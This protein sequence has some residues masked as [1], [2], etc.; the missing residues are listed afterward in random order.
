MF[1]SIDELRLLADG[2][3]AL[4]FAGLVIT[5]LYFAVRVRRTL[6]QVRTAKAD[7]LTDVEQRF[8]SLFSQSPDAVFAY[9]RDGYY[10]A[11]NPAA[12]AIVGF[13]DLDLGV[14]SYRDVAGGGAMHDADFAVFDT[15]FQ[16]ALEGESQTFEVRFTKKDGQRRN[17]ECVFLPILVNDEVVGV[18]SIVKDVTERNIAEEN[19]RILQKSLE[20]SDNAV[21]VVD[22]RDH[23]LPVVFANPAFTVMTGYRMDEVLGQP[24]KRLNG[25]D[26]DPQEIARISETVR[27]GRASSV[28]VK[29]YRRD[30]SPFWNQISLA[31]VKDEYG[32][33]THFTAIM[34]DIS[35]KKAQEKRLAYQATHDALTGLGNR[36][37][38]ED[39]LRHDFQLA[40]RRRNL[41]AVLFIDLDEFKPINDT[42]GHKVGDA[43]L[44]SIARRLQSLVRPAD[45]LARFGGDEFV[46]LLP[47]LNLLTQA[48]EVASRIL[49]SLAQPHQ[50]NGHELYISASIGISVIDDDLEYPEKLLQR[51]DMAMYKA[52][53]RGRDTYEIYS[54]DLDENL[55]RRVTLRNDLQEAISNDQLFLYYQP[56]VDGNGE[57]CGLEALVRWNHPDKGFISPED[58]IPLAEETGQIVQLGNWVTTRACHDARILLE[59]G[60]LR[61]R[62]AVNLS[63]MQFHRPG[64]LATLRSIL[65]QTGLAAE[66]LELELTEGILMKDACGAIATLKEMT[67]MGIATAID[68]FGTGFSS[69][70]YLKD[71]PVD[72]IK[73]DRS[74]VENVVTSPKDAAVCKGVIALAREMGLKVV[75][76]GVETREQ[77][78]YLRNNG[79]EVF[80][81]YHFARPMPLDQ[82]I[83]WARPP[84]G[85]ASAAISL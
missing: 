46:L 23:S 50:V 27:A 43:L 2:A 73:I 57:L 38:F 36:A 75:A 41:L 78:D 63:P 48:E 55:S 20:S 56:Q 77:F 32:N 10:Q 49:E 52:K 47:D 40:E 80:Q 29:S 19:R 42:L 44:I 84:V 68:D 6:W 35:D 76:E 83:A 7:Q 53:Q 70:G 22:I 25:P 54:D 1:N 81:G 62:M 16:N 74:F 72:N 15:A 45:T 11:V 60:L 33:V 64:F 51:A 13:T 67:A 39:R 34:S 8:R 17:Y 31:P 18:F 66:H 21:V 26:T 58:F 59:M 5:P 3:L 65:E 37:L 24:V 69:F 28:T 14:T 79:C 82:L 30:G 85:A 12:Q 9:D 71:L 61:G 4:L